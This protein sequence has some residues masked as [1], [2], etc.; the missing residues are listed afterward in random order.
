MNVSRE[1]VS[2]AAALDI[3]IGIM[4]FLAQL[5]LALLCC[6]SWLSATVDVVPFVLVYVQRLVYSEAKCSA[7]HKN[8]LCLKL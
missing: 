4:T 8:G 1:R 7:V 6:Q 2:V 3:Y 5:Q